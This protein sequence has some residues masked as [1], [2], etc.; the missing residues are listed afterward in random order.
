MPGEEENPSSGYRSSFSHNSEKASPGY[1]S[2]K[3]DDY[4]V[5][6][7]MTAT[8]RAG[9]HKYTYPENEKSGIM[10]DMEHGIGDRTTV[11]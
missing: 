5:F 4:N 8:A 11:V 7:E 10:I 6:A 9:F 2:V 3:L 1:Y